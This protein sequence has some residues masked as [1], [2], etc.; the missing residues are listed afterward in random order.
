MVP[1]DVMIYFF[2]MMSMMCMMDQRWST[3]EFGA[4][5]LIYSLKAFIEQQF[6]PTLDLLQGR[7]HVGLIAVLSTSNV[8]VVQF[9]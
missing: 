8:F 9:L 6:H 4:V 5:F 2:Y 1:I 7:S 3:N